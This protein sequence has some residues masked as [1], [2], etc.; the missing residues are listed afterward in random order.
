[1]KINLFFCFKPTSVSRCC[2][3]VA[4]SRAVKPRMNHNFPDICVLSDECRP[5]LISHSVHKVTSR[6]CCECCSCPRTFSKWY[7]WECKYIKML[8]RVSLKSSYVIWIYYCVMYMWKYFNDDIN[9]M[10]WW[11]ILIM[12]FIG[13]EETKSNVVF[14]QQKFSYT[15]KIYQ[16]LWILIYFIWKYWSLSLWTVVESMMHLSLT[17]HEKINSKRNSLKITSNVAQVRFVSAYDRITLSSNDTWKFHHTKCRSKNTFD[18]IG[19]CA[20][21]R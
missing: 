18:E 15:N 6:R 12:I 9:E 8:F 21:S 7:L 17:I 1:M 4:R 14:E 3:A 13:K 2:A 11:N 5:L 16:Q 19:K 10:K 20:M